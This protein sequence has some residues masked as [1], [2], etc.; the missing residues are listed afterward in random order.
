MFLFTIDEETVEATPVALR[1]PPGGTE[2]PRKRCL[3]DDE[4]KT[5]PLDPKSAA[6]FDRLG[7]ALTLYLLTATRRSELALARWANINFQNKTWLVPAEDSKTEEPLLIPLSAWAVREFEALQRL[8]K[9][10]PWVMPNDERSGPIDPKLLTRGVARCQGRMKRLGIAKFTLHD[11][12]RT[13]RTG[14]AKL[15]VLPHIAERCLNRAQKGIE[16]TY[17]VYDYLD[18]KREALNIWAAY[19]ETLAPGAAAPKTLP[20]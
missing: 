18:E 16:S 15:K 9:H 4:L 17:N 2:K 10:S 20:A 11:M 7:H 1:K 5:L 12:R 6:R 14:M 3:S 13:C 19:L 8:A